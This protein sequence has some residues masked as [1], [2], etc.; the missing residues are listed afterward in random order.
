MDPIENQDGADPRPAPRRV[1]AGAVLLGILGAACAMLGF[2]LAPLITVPV[3]QR[4]YAVLGFALLGAG[5]AMLLAA[6]ARGRR[7]V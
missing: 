3:V 7:S 2:M 6:F 1:P 4:K 5:V